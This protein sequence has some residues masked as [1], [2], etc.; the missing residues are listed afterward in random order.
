VPYI[1]AKDTK[2]KRVL[3]GG[4][5]SESQETSWVE[6]QSQDVY[7]KF[8]G[9]EAAPDESV[10][11]E[12]IEEGR[13]YNTSYVPRSNLEGGGEN[14]CQ[15]VDPDAPYGLWAG[16]HLNQAKRI[17]A[18]RYQAKISERQFAYQ[19]MREFLETAMHGR[20]GKLE[21]PSMPVGM[22]SQMLL[23]MS[24]YLGNSEHS[25]YQVSEELGL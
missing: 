17:L 21:I 7:E 9:W 1:I 4:L 3:L 24:L 13:R 6:Y 22:L 18:V 5:G 25:G 11:R 16:Y 12:S 14:H 10:T 23:S 2:Q 15:G 20:G 8:P 19:A